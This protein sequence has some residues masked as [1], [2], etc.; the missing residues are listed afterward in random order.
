MYIRKET[1]QIAI[2]FALASAEPQ[3]N[4]FF[5]LFFSMSLQM[6]LKSSYEGSM[7]L[8]VSG[9]ES[10]THSFVFLHGYDCSGKFDAE[11]HPS[12]AHANTTKYTGLRV[13][14]PDAHLLNTSASGYKKVFS[15]RNYEVHHQVEVQG[16]ASVFSFMLR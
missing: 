7:T 10:P 15:T 3:K 2:Q 4:D 5:A 6:V 13:V 1:S 14:C 9:S 8:H 12:W 16:P 11:H